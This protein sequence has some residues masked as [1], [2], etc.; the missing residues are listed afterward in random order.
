MVSTAWWALRETVATS[1]K[2]A[3]AVNASL[4]RFKII[5]AQPVGGPMECTTWDDID[6][7]LER[8]NH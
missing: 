8:T 1:V 3:D 7:I 4:E 2:Q 5:S 6:Q